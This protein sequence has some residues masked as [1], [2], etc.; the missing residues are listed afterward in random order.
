M[1]LLVIPLIEKIE[2]SFQNVFQQQMF[3]PKTENYSAFELLICSDVQL[4]HF[5]CH[6]PTVDCVDWPFSI[7]LTIAKDKVE[8]T[9]SIRSSANKSIH[10]ANWLRD[11]MSHSFEEPFCGT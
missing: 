6:R 7:H 8:Y 11:F 5:Q 1:G 3:C 9:W 2:N 10:V 4:D